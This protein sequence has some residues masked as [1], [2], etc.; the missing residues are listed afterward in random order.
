MQLKCPD[1]MADVLSANVQHLSTSHSVDLCG[2]HYFFQFDKVVNRLDRSLQ[3]VAQHKKLVLNLHGQVQ[4]DLPPA[5][6]VP[7]YQ[8]IELPVVGS[9]LTLKYLGQY[10][11]MFDSPAEEPVPTWLAMSWLLEDYGLSRNEDIPA[12][13]QYKRISRQWSEVPPVAVL[14]HP[15]FCDCPRRCKWDPKATLT[16][17]E[18]N[19]PLIQGPKSTAAEC[20][21]TYFKF[22]QSHIHHKDPVCFRAAVFSKALSD[23]CGQWNVTIDINQFH[24]SHHEFLLLLKLQ[25]R[26]T[27]WVRL[28]EVMA[29]SHFIAGAHKCLINE[30][31]NTRAGPF[32]RFLRWQRLNAPELVARDEDLQRAIEKVET[33]ELKRGAEEA[34]QQQRRPPKLLRK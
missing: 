26:P 18:Y 10:E 12:D 17:L 6:F 2:S 23:W 27:R 34:A 21:A 31:P 8:T 1:F 16:S 7:A 11:N 29:I 13:I 9:P 3:E 24:D 22:F 32:E 5:E 30:F 33:R 20:K 15:H 4:F 19:W 14:T 25:Y 28:V